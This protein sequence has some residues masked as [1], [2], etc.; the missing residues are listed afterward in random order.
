MSPRKKYLQGVALLAFATL[1]GLAIPWLS[2]SI[3]SVGMQIYMLAPGLEHDNA[4]ADYLLGLATAA[5]ITLAIILWPMQN[6]TKRKDLVPLWLMRCAVTLGFMLIYE[7]NYSIDAFAYFGESL[8][9]VPRYPLKSGD[10][11]ALFINI[12]WW[13]NQ[14]ILPFPSYHT[15]KLL[16]ALIGFGGSNLVYGAITRLLGRDDRRM[17]WIAHLCPSILFWSSI[18]GKDPLTFIAVSAY[19]YGISGILTKQQAVSSILWIASGALLSFIFRPWM[20]GILAAPLLAMPVIRI[21][22]PILRIIAIALV[23]VA[24]QFS[25]NYLSQSLNISSTSEVLEMTNQISRSWSRGGSGQEVPEFK[26]SGDMLAFAPIGMF[27]ALFRPLP[28]EVL[29]PFGLLAGFENIVLLVALIFGIRRGW[30][31]K[32]L[33]DDRVIALIS[34]VLSWSFVYGFVSYQNLGAAVRFKLQ[35]LPALLALILFLNY[36]KAQTNVRH[37]RNT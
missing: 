14:N 20:V 11:Y 5:A 23:P 31:E 10:T 16:F 37:S 15:Q 36:Y 26:T 8:Y 33:T 6:P 1:L 2:E 13:I 28:G 18:L 32:M 35:I 25:T 29:N 30:R 17:L 27:T 24:L 22:Q 21:K 34:V 19:V 3:E 9:S 7:K 12:C 4:L